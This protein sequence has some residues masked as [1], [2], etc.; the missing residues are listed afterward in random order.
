MSLAVIGIAQVDNQASV[1]YIFRCESDPKQDA[2]QIR[3]ALH[4]AMHLATSKHFGPE[5]S[6]SSGVINCM[7]HTPR[8]WGASP[9]LP[10]PALMRTSD[11]FFPDRPDSHR[12]HLF[13]NVWNNLL[14]RPL[15]L[16]PDLDMLMTF[17]PFARYHAALRTFSPSPIYVTD[18][19]G[20][21]N[22]DLVTKGLI[23]PLKKGGDA[24]VKTR[25]EIGAVLASTAVA[26]D[27]VMKDEWGVAKVGLAVGSADGAVIGL[28]NVKKGLETATDVITRRDIIDALDPAPKQGAVYALF[29]SNAAT[30]IALDPFDGKIDDSVAV[31]SVDLPATGHEIATISSFHPLPGVP[32]AT[33]AAVGLVDAICGLSAITKVGVET[34]PLGRPTVDVSTLSSSAGLSVPL[35]S[36]ITKPRQPSFARSDASAT[37]ATSVSSGLS[38]SSRYGATDPFQIG[39]NIWRG[40]PPT[41]PGRIRY[42][43]SYVAGDRQPN[44]DSSIALASLRRDLGRRPVRT[45]LNEAKAFMRL[46]ATLMI[47]AAS[48]FWSRVWQA[49]RIE[50]G[51]VAQQDDEKKSL[52]S[53]PSPMASP[54]YATSPT[55]SEVDLDEKQPFVESSFVPPASPIVRTPDIDI[56]AGEEVFRI[57]TPFTGKIRFVINFSD[58]P[59]PPLTTEG[60]DA[61]GAKI[62]VAVD[63]KAVESALEYR[64]CGDK[65]GR[66]WTVDVDLA[67]VAQTQVDAVGGDTWVVEVRA[68]K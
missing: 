32:N 3:S 35:L 25:K 53:G 13:V 28:W 61:V 33:I 37:T 36:S 56:N 26:R 6:A 65:A 67:A 48:T 27:D 52:L 40:V 57:E 38:F 46:F 42:L 7:S 64:A 45:V 20:E 14:A 60:A 63:G 11:D 55:I 16:E 1:D 51:R 59:Q 31:A 68:R 39:R 17:H 34:K 10:A 23:A 5:T 18:K 54:S 49:G 21:H 22:E 66:A 41:Q 8:T 29:L 19:P 43:I 47:V 44:S 15:G 30:F 9:L 50:A 4:E 62:L 24:V 12:W 58:W 2:G